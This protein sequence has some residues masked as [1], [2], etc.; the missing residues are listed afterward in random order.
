MRVVT[1]DPGKEKVGTM[2]DVTHLT[3]TI[4]EPIFHE[5]FRLGLK[6]TVKKNHSI[7]SE[8]I[9]HEKGEG[10]QFFLGL[11]VVWTKLQV[12]AED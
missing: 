5:N 7:L 11:K 1:G 3:S 10:F 6:I 2:G 9:F 12:G 4:S 8:P